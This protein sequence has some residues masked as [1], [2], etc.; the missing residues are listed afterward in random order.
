MTCVWDT[1]I[2]CI[3]KDE[4]TQ[5]ILG[6]YNSPLD[7]VKR[8]KNSNTMIEGILWQGVEVSKKQQEENFEWIRDYNENSIQNGHLTSSAD[9][10]IMLVAYLLRIEVIFIF[11][12][13]RIVIYPPGNARYNITLR[14]NGGH[15]R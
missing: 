7:F 2:R 14:G 13:Y 5:R 8:L 15:M 4:V 12:G 10:F 9:P 1:L 11:N 6:D 3:K